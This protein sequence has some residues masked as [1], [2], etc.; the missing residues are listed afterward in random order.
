MIT[1]QTPTI[2]QTVKGIDLCYCKKAMRKG[3][4]IDRKYFVQ[5]EALPHRL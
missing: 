4:D 3:I 2:Q 1:I 5:T